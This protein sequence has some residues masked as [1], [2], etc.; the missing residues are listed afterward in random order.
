MSGF[1]P[2]SPT[3]DFQA[4]A[5]SLGGAAGGHAGYVFKSDGAGG[6]TMVPN[7]QAIAHHLTVGS[8][9]QDVEYS[10]IAAAVSAAIAGGASAAVPWEIV[11]FPGTYVEPPMAI[12]DGIVLTAS[13]GERPDATFV[14]ASDPD[15]DLFTLTGS[16][17]VSGF[18]AGGVTDPARCVFR[19]SGATAAITMRG[20]TI[21]SCSNGIIVENGATLLVNNLVCLITSSD[22]G[23]VGTILKATGAQTEVFVISGV[24]FINP[25][26]LPSYASNPIQTAFD[27][28]DGAKIHL[29]AVD[30]NMPSKDNTAVAFEVGG[31]SYAEIA[32]CSFEN[33]DVAVHTNASG[34]GTD[35]VVQGTFFTGNTLNYKN[36]SSTGKVFG[37]WSTDQRVFSNVPGARMQ[38]YVQ[39]RDDG[40]ARLLGN[41]RYN[42]IETNK[43]VDIADFFSDNIS[44]GL[45]EGGIVTNAGGLFVDISAGNGW[46]HRTAFDDSFQVVWDAYNSL[47]LVPSAT[48]YVYYD[49][50]LTT[51][52]ANVSPPGDTGILM[53]TV[54]TDG[55]GIRFLHRTA[56]P[57]EDHVERLNSYLLAT[58]KFALNSGLACIQGSDS[59]TTK[60]K[61]NVG[62]GSYYC[63]L[64]LI[65]VDGSGGDATFS[66]FY[67]PNG[68]TEVAGQT[69]V[70]IDSYDN[71][72]V[73]TTMADGYFRVDLAVITSDNRI[74]VVYGTSQYS[75]MDL[76]QAAPQVNIPTFIQETGF[77]T[78]SIIVQKNTGISLIVD[79]RPVPG[80]THGTGSTGVT[81]HSQLAGLDA[82]DH[83]QY[84]LVTGARAMTGNLQ[85]GGHSIT[86]VNTIDSVDITAH[87]VRHQPG[88]VDAIAT[89]VPVASLFG[90]VP[91]EGV[92]ASLARSDHQHGLVTGTPSTVGT[93]NAEGT[94]S[95][96]PRLDHVHAHG[97]Q[98]DGTL[99]AAAIASGASG[100]MTGADKAK[101]DGISAN[102]A[103]LTASAPADVAKTAAAAGVGTTAARSDHQHSISTGAPVAGAVVIANSASEGTATS[104]ARSDHQHAVAA[105]SP[106]AVGFA[107]SDGIAT[108]FPRSD[109]VHAH[110]QQTDGYLHQ[111]ATTGL[112]GFMDGTDKQKLN[113][114]SPFAAALTSSAPVDVSKT[115]AAAGVGTTAARSDHQHS[116]STAAPGTVT[117]GVAAEGSA[118][119]LARSDHAHA[120]TA[121]NAPANVDKSAA[122]AGSSANV[123]RQDHKHDVS[124]G[125]P[126]TVTYGSAAEGVATTL[127]RSDHAHA[128][129]APVAP[130]N[131]TKAAAAAGSSANVAR[132]DHKHD[133]S[134]AVVG[135]VTFGSATEGTATTLARSDH[136]HALTAPNAPANV[137]KSAA[138]AGSSAN[139][140]REDHKH[141]VSTAVVG[142]VTFG[143]AAEGSATSL[144]RSDHNHALTAPTAPVNVDK[145]AAAAGSSANVAR[146]DHKHDVSTAVVGTVTFGSAAEGTATTL[147][148]SD[149]NHALTAPTAPANVDKSAASAGSSANVAR[150][151]HKHDV[152]TAAPAAGAV[153]IGNSASEGTATTIARSDHQHAVTDGTPVAVGTANANGVATTFSRSDHV[154]AP[155]TVFGLNYQTAI[156]TARTTTTSSAMQTKVTLTTPALTGTFR[157]GWMAVGDVGS[158]DQRFQVQLLNV[159]DAAIL[160]DTQEYSL[161]N[162]TNKVKAGGF[163]E[164]V[165]TGALKS[166]SI[167]FASP[168]NSTTVGIQDARI[169]FWRV[170]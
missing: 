81:V 122:A 68:A 67:G 162:T 75:S 88:G 56:V 26:A 138:S 57:N 46:I 131:V 34:T 97:A 7:T 39:Y 101:L 137:D 27:T 135:T 21:S 149:H 106:V 19:I 13:N 16:G 147:A 50:D 143:A 148:R 120:L 4:V 18:R 87:A 146:Q 47:P 133:V 165:F 76:A 49:T 168:N 164:V 60:R 151:D 80:T 100:F 89:A 123:A 116:I 134:T 32:S 62:S 40:Y 61:I 23:T 53:A 44:T 69:Q 160:G 102:A 35:V 112:P 121:P 114:I 163:G 31:G 36:E 113:G 83:K 71:G 77:Q 48:N 52:V 79:V 51:F 94:S 42:Y 145:S 33:C 73:L 63:G 72:G 24:I 41:T 124:T 108:T 119:S 6:G 99:H 115:T 11:V 30:I 38:G 107:S 66:Y 144:A 142:T 157:V 10:S 111:V 110:G 125:T 59:G 129:T 154:H 130:A 136:N 9:G 14:T 91:A 25:L 155:L 95:S 45:D 117:F 96:G 84:L 170:S 158:G 98:T 128:L 156:A 150:Q 82:D 65:L 8:M 109:H 43:D 15:S 17:L 127:A 92:A 85:M 78:G 2:Q 58:R 37:T 3:G 152:S 28:G 167:R 141:D 1:L 5:A 132:E 22:F 161:R 90:V 74:S 64:D 139:V 166:F 12:S 140:A 159:T 70:D 169:E 126:G 54:V 20:I 103:A 105:G 153:A 93:V 55:S 29:Q 86:G 104:L 118:S